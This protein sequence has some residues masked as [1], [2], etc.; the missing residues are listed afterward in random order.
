MMPVQ[1]NE[2]SGCREHTT[3][4]TLMAVFVNKFLDW[5]TAKNISKKKG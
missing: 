5:F 3:L 4:L 1:D 2:T